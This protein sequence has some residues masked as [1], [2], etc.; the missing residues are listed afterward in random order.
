MLPSNS[1][2]FA[3]LKSL[4]DGEP[5]AITQ[6]FLN[7][8]EENRH[9]Y[10]FLLLTKE[11]L[12]IVTMVA[13]FFLTPAGERY[14]TRRMAYQNSEAA[15]MAHAENYG[16]V[17]I[18]YGSEIATVKKVPLRSVRILHYGRGLATHEIE[19][20]FMKE[21][22][23]D[24]SADSGEFYPVAFVME[25]NIARTQ[26]TIIATLESGLDEFAEA[27]SAALSARPWWKKIVSRIYPR[28]DWSNFL[29]NS[30]YWHW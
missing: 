25:F 24:L 28:L 15:A 19:C 30:K 11:T 22:G 21:F 10:R 14:Y 27:S 4:C 23:I 8:Q 12:L 7:R 20:S 18:K 6:G 3:A 13:D 5:L 29:R 16:G 17:Y 2:T 1:E 26:W 9:D